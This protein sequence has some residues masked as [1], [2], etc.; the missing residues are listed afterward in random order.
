M[1]RHFRNAVGCRDYVHARL[2]RSRQCWHDNGR[3][4]GYGYSASAH[5]LRCKLTAYEYNVSGTA[6]EYSHETADAAFLA[7][8]EKRRCREVLT[9]TADRI[10]A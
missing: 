2:P 7:P 3:Y 10:K 6:D 5:E 1:Q 4:A 9:A 8:L